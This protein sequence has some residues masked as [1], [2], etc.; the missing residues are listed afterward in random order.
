MIGP[1]ARRC[2][3]AMALAACL[4]GG[5]ACAQTDSPAEGTLADAWALMHGARQVWGDGTSGEAEAMVRRALAIRE[6]LLG[7]QDP[8]VA[9]SIDELGKIAYN[10]GR[11]GEAE[12]RFRRAV[13]IDEAALGPNALEVGLLLGDL[14]AALRELH[15]YRE[16]EAIVLRSLAIRRG[17]LP[18]DDL[19]IAG[20]LNNLGRLYLRE[21]RFAEA[22]AAFVES[23]AIYEAALPANDAIVRDGAALIEQAH[24]ANLRF[25]NLLTA[26]ARWGG[27]WLMAMFGLIGLNIWTERRQ[28]A[29]AGMPRPVGVT[30][31]AAIAWLGYLAGAVYLGSLTLSWLLWRTLPSEAGDYL[32]NRNT[33]KLLGLLAAWIAVMIFQFAANFGRAVFGLPPRKM[34]LIGSTAFRR[35]QTSSGGSGSSSDVPDRPPLGVAL[36]SV[37]AALW[38]GHLV[39]SLPVVILLIPGLAGGV[40]AGIAVGNEF[41]LNDASGIILSVVGLVAGMVP[42]W[43]WWSVAVPKW[44]LWALQH[45]EN[46][47]ELKR[48]AIA[49]GLIWPDGHIF[50]KTEIRSAAGA[51]FEQEWQDRRAGRY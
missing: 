47:P 24:A 31:A 39:V 23:Q 41:G 9:A 27:L 26:S 13:E 19:W 42:A 50:G 28:L 34:T 37:S 43:L 22:E 29:G 20:G 8:Q 36:C 16:A 10:R 32:A 14:G 48:R 44:R 2:L 49:S 15:R 7:P 12:S 51:R 18:P 21:G 35:H 45:V 40:T 6:A 11:Y 5:F 25:H 30:V 1:L 4:I 17:V 46:W 3:T 38:R 33:G